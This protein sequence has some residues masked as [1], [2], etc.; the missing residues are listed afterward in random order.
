MNTQA[1]PSKGGAHKVGVYGLPRYSLRPHWILSVARRS[2]SH[3]LPRCRP[4]CSRKWLNSNKQN[5]KKIHPCVRRVG[6]VTPSAVRRKRLLS[7]YLERNPN[8]Y[9]RSTSVH[10]RYRIVSYRHAYYVVYGSGRQVEEEKMFQT[11]QK[12]I[13]SNVHTLVLSSG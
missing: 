3:H 7:H 2:L 4:L 8:K 11:R 5:H 13:H 1:V 12:C 6:V 9:I 10:T